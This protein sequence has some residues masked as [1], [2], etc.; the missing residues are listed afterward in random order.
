MSINWG[1][2][3]R[4]GLMFSISENVLLSTEATYYLRYFNDSQSITG[5]LDSNQRSSEFRLTLPI[6]LFLSVKLGGPQKD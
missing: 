4:V 3:P 5:Q 2:G 1:L 6:T